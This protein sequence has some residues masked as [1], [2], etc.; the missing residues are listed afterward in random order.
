MRI[1]VELVV[2][3][4]VKWIEA[5]PDAAFSRF[6]VARH[7]PRTDTVRM[8]KLERFRSGITF[9]SWAIDSFCIAGILAYVVWGLN[10]LSQDNAIFL[11]TFFSLTLWAIVCLAAGLC[12]LVRAII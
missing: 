2:H 4:V 3:A 5:H 10:W 7:G 9:L 8:T 12:L 11:F 6:M 1:L